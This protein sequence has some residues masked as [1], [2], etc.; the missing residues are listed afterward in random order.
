MQIFIKTYTGRNIALVV[1]RKEYIED[2]K[3]KIQ[4]KEGIPLDYQRLIYASKQ[5][6]NGSTLFDYSIENDS[7]LY[8]LLDLRGGMQIFVKTLTG[9]YIALAVEPTDRIEDLKL[10]IQEREG[11]A[12]E[13]Q[14]LLFGDQKL[15]DENTL[16]DY[17]IQK[18][19]IIRI[20]LQLC[21]G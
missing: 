8:L 7:T 16:E 17:F 14:C 2:I 13:Q 11:I 15:N 3:T 1:E 21:G 10:K 18:F 19:S 5:L 9:L 20:V 6:Q 4:Y 12:P